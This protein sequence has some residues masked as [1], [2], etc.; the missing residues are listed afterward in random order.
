MVE[1]FHV[2][3]LVD[4][5]NLLLQM[6]TLYNLTYTVQ[7]AEILL[8]ITSNMITLQRYLRNLMKPSETDRL[9]AFY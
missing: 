9:N 5:K 3:D 2:K 6:E 4:L 1:I 8:R 7:E